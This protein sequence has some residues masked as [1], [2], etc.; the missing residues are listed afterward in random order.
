MILKTFFSARVNLSMCT[1][2]T[3][4]G[5]V[6]YFGLLFR[7]LHGPLPSFA[8]VAFHYGIRIILVTLLTMLTFKII[9]KILFILD[10][11]RMTMIPEST[12]MCFLCACTTF[13]IVSHVALEVLLRN[14]RGL[15][16]YPRWCLVVYISKVTTLQSCIIIS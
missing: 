14:L 4:C 3:T 10:F 1:V 5:I 16:H 2:L 13:S 15:Q 12:I 11:D 6:L 9:V 7:I 8:A